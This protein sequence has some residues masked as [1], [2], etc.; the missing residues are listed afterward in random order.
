MNPIASAKAILSFLDALPMNPPVKTMSIGGTSLTYV[1]QGTGLPVV[2]VHGWFSDHRIWEPQRE[3]IAQRY[4]FIAIDQRYFG[5]APWPD[6]GGQFSPATHAADLAAFIR[7]LNAGSVHLVGQSDGSSISLATAIDHP[8]LV[9]SLFLNEPQAPSLLTD[10]SDRTLAEDD[11]KGAAA[12]RAA[13]DAGKSTEAMKLFL[14]FSTNQQGAFA[15]LPAAARAMR[16]DNARTAPLALNA[17]P[18]SITCAQAGQL[19]VPVILTKGEF[20]RTF[21]RVVTEAVSR[22]IPGAQLITIKGA[23]NGA[24]S[25][26]PAAFNDALL[27]FLARQ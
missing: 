1:E 15:A 25:Q 22:C 18:V 13:T 24:P 8:G 26:Q 17:P 14:D 12:A 11:R 27:A 23:M 16:L 5:T 7:G 9:R 19:K 20:T 3:A 21:Y 10:P 2:F 4:R 6:G